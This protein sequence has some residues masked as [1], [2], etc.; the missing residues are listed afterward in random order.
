MAASSDIVILDWDETVFPMW[1]GA[2]D[3]HSMGEAVARSGWER[4][5]CRM[6]EKL[7]EDGAVV[8]ILTNAGAGH[9]EDSCQTHM[10]QLWQQHVCTVPVVSARQNESKY[11]LTKDM[12][13]WKFMAMQKAIKPLVDKLSPIRESVNLFGIGDAETD[14]TALMMFGEQM[15]HVYPNV[16]H[17]TIKLP[18]KIPSSP[19]CVDQVK[20][21]AHILQERKRLVGNDLQLVYLED[22]SMS[23]R[24]STPT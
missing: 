14:R 22:G 12:G 17:T 1:M 2:G 13:V 10:R 8:V 21:L 7:S 20:T 11:P 24:K 4:A 16:T 19:E 23:L 15:A 9:V 18:V 6:F 5:W 3:P